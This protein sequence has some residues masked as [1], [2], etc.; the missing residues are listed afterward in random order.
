MFSCISLRIAFDPA[1][2]HVASPHIT[3]VQAVQ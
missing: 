2:A 1:V 3:H